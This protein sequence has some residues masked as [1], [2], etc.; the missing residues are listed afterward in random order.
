VGLLDIAMKMF[1]LML[2]L[3]A[4][5]VTPASAQTTQPAPKAWEH[6]V[7]NLSTALAAGN[8]ECGTHLADECTVRS[9]RSSL[10]LLADLTAHTNGASVLL[11]KGYLF[12]S[13]SIATDIAGAVQDS[14]APDEVKKILVPAD[15]D[16]AA[17]A[18]ATAT[19]WAQSALSLG[20]S[21]AF[22]V[23]VFLKN[24]SGSAQAAESKVFFVLLKARSS[25]DGSYRVTQIVYGDSQQA[26]V[27]A[28]R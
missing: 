21:D 5:L 4:L 7:Q 14:E 28:A 17:R 9:F 11:A 16:A 8:E 18:N 13:E 2:C 6:I 10:K 3:G 19:R 20:N 27:A 1:L 26:T 22:A 15:A 12:P 23:M 25:A 24:D